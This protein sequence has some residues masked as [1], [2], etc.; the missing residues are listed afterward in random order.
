[1]LSHVQ[2]AI[3][4]ADMTRGIDPD[5]RQRQ[6]SASF[7]EYRYRPL[8]TPTLKTL[9]LNTENVQCLACDMMHHLV[10]S[11]RAVV[12]REQRR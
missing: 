9:G 4:A 12:E 8:L 10:H 5:T 7:S 3:W 2:K 6:T 1:M 11:L